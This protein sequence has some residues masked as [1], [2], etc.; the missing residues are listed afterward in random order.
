[1]TRFEP[2]ISVAGSDLS[3]DCDTTTVHRLNMISHKTFR[4][5]GIVIRGHIA[6]S[7][8]KSPRLSMR[9]LVTFCHGPIF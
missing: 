1:M 8:L 7:L 6:I 5:I 4:S 2:T 3:T 9:P